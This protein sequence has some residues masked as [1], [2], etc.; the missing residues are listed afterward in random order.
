LD[1]KEPITCKQIAP[2]ESRRA[3]AGKHRLKT[4]PRAVV[5]V[6]NIQ[7]R[8]FAFMAYASIAMHY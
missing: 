4:S 1:L 6:A 5:D 7:R 2:P 8:R 3:T